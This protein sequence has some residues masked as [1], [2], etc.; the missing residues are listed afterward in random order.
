MDRKKIIL[1]WLLGC[2][3]VMLITSCVSMVAWHFNFQP[4]TSTNWKPIN[5]IWGMIFLVPAGWL[6]SF[7]TPFGWA[8]LFFMCISVYTK[9][10]G[11]LAGSAIATILTGIFWPMTYVTMLDLQTQVSPAIVP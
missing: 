8:S 1:I 11:L 5:H 2:I 9:L 10:P 4:D 7:M 6:L 3:V